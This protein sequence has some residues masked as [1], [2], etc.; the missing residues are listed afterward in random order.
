MVELDARRD[1]LVH[2]RGLHLALAR[3]EDLVVPASARP[4]VVVNQQE[5]YVRFSGG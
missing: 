3:G 2:V 4:A 5:E 1:E